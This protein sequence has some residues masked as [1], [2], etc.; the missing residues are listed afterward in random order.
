MSNAVYSSQSEFAAFVGIDWAD[1]KHV[2]ALQVSDSLLF[3]QGELV[4]RS[5]NLAG[6]QNQRLRRFKCDVVTG[7]TERSLPYG[8]SFRTLRDMA[9][10]RHPRARK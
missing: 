9:G 4:V 1:R 3:E 6:T 2:W 7:V 8:L 10:R 5:Q